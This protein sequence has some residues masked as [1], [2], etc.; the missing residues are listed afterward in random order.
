MEI[1]IIG[2]GAT[3]M[4]LAHYLGDN[5]QVTLYVRRK[6][7]AASIESKGI[8]LAVTNITTIIHVRQIDE[9]IRNHAILF[10]CVK[11]NHLDH[12]TPVLNKIADSTTV[13][14]LQN[15]M[16]HI[17]KAKELSA[18]VMV[19]VIEHGALKVSDHTVRHSGKGI[20][21]VAYLTGSV[22]S[23]SLVERLNQE[24]FPFVLEP[25]YYPMLAKKLV[26]NAVINPLTA[27]FEIR[28]GQL[29]DNP[30]LTQLARQLCREAC[31]V[32]HLDEIEEWTNV[33]QIARAT[34]G[35]YS[36]MYKDITN[37]RTTEIDAI[38][39]YLLKN[40]T[41]QISGHALLLQAIKAKQYEKRK[42]G[43]DE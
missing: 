38:T 12:L 8:Q 40:S 6:E 35:N 31:Q 25:D 37:G 9:G 30:F 41:E 39:G 5:H 22:D 2:G 27:L 20:I 11:Q 4:L 26:I 18:N 10:V 3:G 14:F 1:G 32:L 42:E 33:M 29:L 36:S 28:N 43:E 19:G 24:N 17:E 23:I 16:A 34:A 15:G 7:Q 21:R 13:I